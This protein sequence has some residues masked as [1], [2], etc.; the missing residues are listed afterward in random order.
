MSAY[1]WQLSAIELNQKTL[2]T[3]TLLKGRRRL[4]SDTSTIFGNFLQIIRSYSTNVYGNSEITIHMGDFSETL[5]TTKNGFFSIMI[6]E[7]LNENISVTI[8]DITLELPQNYPVL[9]RQNNSD[10]EV[11]S[12]IDDTILLS[13]TASALKRITT[14]LFYRPKRRKTIAYTHDLF[15]RFYNSGYRIN[16][17]SKSESNL[18]GLITSVLHF[19]ELS[20]GPLLLTPFLS[21]RQL[22]NPK[23]GEDYKLNY[24]R[25]LMN[26]MPD[27]KFILL[28]DDS[29]RDM[30]VYT[31]AIEEY[32][33]RIRKVFIRQTRLTRKAIQ[34]EKWNRLLE[35]GIDAVY[36]QDSD[37]V[38]EEMEKKPIEN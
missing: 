38:G 7:P 23:K 12:D 14:I 30:D 15:K 33:E 35:S 2:I 1:I 21:F 3:G 31:Q 13:H 11:I 18:F 10:T 19:R 26:Q 27:K 9:F 17:L 16:Y 6:D 37:E 32:P 20:E 34:D 36:F 5:N 29:Q 22:F 25:L 28:G 8:N 4:K 24:L